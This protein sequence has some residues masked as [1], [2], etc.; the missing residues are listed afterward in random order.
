MKRMLLAV[1]ADKM[2]SNRF[3]DYIS[4]HKNML[5]DFIIFTSVDNTREYVK[6]GKIDIL[7]VDE[8]MSGGA[9]ELSNIKKIIILSDGGYTGQPACPVIFKY[10]S[11]G[12]ILKEIF[13]QA[14]DDDNIPGIASIC[15]SKQAELITV[16]SP[17]GGA[18]TSTYS[19]SLCAGMAASNNVLYINLEAFDSFAEFESNAE[20]QGYIC[21]MS[22]AVYYIKHKKDKLAFK[23]ESIIKHHNDGYSYIL[24]VEDYRDLYSISSDDIECFADIITSSMMYDKVV[25]DTGCI[26]EALLKLFEISDV[27]ILPKASGTIQE[28]KQHSFERLLVRNGMDK[29]LHN[30]K[31]V[32]MKGRQVSN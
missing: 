21:G 10:Q 12:R 3:S 11:A 18:G 14:A 22:E 17:Y 6:K 32:V 7:L 13:A 4:H 8:S 24:P 20:R 16:F 19:K 29:T 5:A 2:Y 1:L 25:F 28:N 9:L 30:I 26:N 15:A 31:Y 27:L 23:M